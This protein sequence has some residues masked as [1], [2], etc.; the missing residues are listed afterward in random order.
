MQFNYKVGDEIEHRSV[1]G[2]HWQRA[3]VSSL[4]PYRGKPGYYVTNLPIRSLS[5]GSAGGWVYEA[6]MRPAEAR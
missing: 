6:V 5:E 4:A 2:G 3:Y 1:N